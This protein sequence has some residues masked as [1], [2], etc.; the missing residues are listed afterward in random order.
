M[1]DSNQRGLTDQQ[2]DALT[3]DNELM[4]LIKRPELFL[5]IR[6]GYFN[7]YF[8]GASA[9]RFSFPDTGGL[10]I[11]THHKYLGTD[12]K[13]YQTISRDEFLY[14]LD[15]I[16]TSIQTHQKSGKGWEE[17]VAQQALLMA[18]NR[19]PDSGWY[20]ADMEYVQQRQSSRE[21]CYGRFDIVAI[22]RAPGAEGRHRAALIEL[23]VG[24]ASY[25]SKLPKEIREQIEDGTFSIDRCETS[26]GSGIV[27]HLA[28]FYRFEKAGQ[29]RQLREEIC[30]ILSNKRDLGCSVPCAGIQPDE[31]AVQPYF[32]VLTLCGDIPSCKET[33]CRY[34]G[35]DRYT[36]LSKYN[37]RKILGRT[38]LDYENYRFLFA[39]LDF[40]DAPVVDILGDA[41]IEELWHPSENPF[42]KT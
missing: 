18:N 5:G 27:G 26:L 40:P 37:A 21:P 28:D 20:C 31:I 10:K 14:R 9:G 33:M 39:P 41:S 11:E 17:K 30:Q 7:L 19:N 29:F 42:H 25:E 23:K 32:Y 4:T 15:G 8:L 22:S 24:S 2:I 3:H 35:I 6:N 34:L 38:F 12:G 1:S 13:G 16:L 36:R